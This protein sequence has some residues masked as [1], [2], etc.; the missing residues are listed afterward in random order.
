RAH[1]PLAPLQL[2]SMN[3]VLFLFAFG[4]IVRGSSGP[5][6]RR[7]RDVPKL[8]SG[9]E[10]LDA[11]LSASRGRRTDVNDAARLLLCRRTLDEQRLSLDRLG[12]ERN[13]RAV[14]IDDQ[15]A[16]LFFERV[17]GIVAGNGNR[18]IQQDAV[19]PAT[20]VLTR[21]GG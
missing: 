3:A 17:L 19:A 1:Q 20:A 10:E 13:Q 9:F 16:R 7:E 11:E 6:V 5:I 4:E 8:W 21:T 18:N 14:G 12:L 2:I 15:R